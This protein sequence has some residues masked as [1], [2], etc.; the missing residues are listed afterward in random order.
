MDIKK[1]LYLNSCSFLYADYTI[2]GGNYLLSKKSIL[3][4]LF[5][6]SSYIASGLGSNNEAI[7]RRTLIDCSK[8]DFDFAIIGWSHP[9]RTLLVDRRINID[10]KILKEESDLNFLGTGPRKPTYGYIDKIPG[11][12]DEHNMFLKFEPK[13]TDDT[14]LYTISLHN[15]FKQRNIPHL[16]LNMGKLD[17]NVLEARKSWL[18]GIDKKNYLS[19]S[20]GDD[21]LEKMKFS[22]IEHY[23]KKAGKIVVKDLD[24]HKYKFLE[25]NNNKWVVDIG[26]HLGE[27]AYDDLFKLIYNHIIENNLLN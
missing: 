6:E 17:S 16:F 1:R 7:F 14:I 23:G 19:I 11:E 2:P 18:N 22:F 15:F 8:N 25:D 27:S 4:K 26:G 3:S 10:Y 21:I 9:E 12:N 20:I 13:G 5:T 24:I